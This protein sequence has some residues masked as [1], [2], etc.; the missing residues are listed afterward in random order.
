MMIE[1]TNLSKKFRKKEVLREV[2]LSLESG[3]YG[4]L[5]PNGAGKTTLLRCMLG[6]YP[7]R[8]GEIKLNI[9][10]WQIGYLPQ[11]F[12]LFRELSVYDM[13]YYF[14]ELKKIPKTDREKAIFQALDSVNLVENKKTRISK[15]SG[16]MQRRVGIAQAILGKPPLIVFDEPTVGLDPEERKRFK[17]MV[18]KRKENSII[19]FSTHIVGDIE[20]VC[21]K[22]IIMNKGKIIREGKISEIC[23]NSE[24]AGGLEEAYLNIINETEV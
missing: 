5:G 4:M 19:L 11:S 10:N 15:L 18:L 23:Q 6:L 7:V 20:D 14:C 9:P 22:I 16:G 13:L 1:I 8:K 12:G 3:A 24:S 2:C 21:D 17:D